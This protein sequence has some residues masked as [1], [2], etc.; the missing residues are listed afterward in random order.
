M[1]SSVTGHIEVSLDPPKDPHDV[2][3]V[4][5][6]FGVSFFVTVWALLEQPLKDF[7]VGLPSTWIKPE[8]PDVTVLLCPTGTY[9]RDQADE[10]LKHPERSRDWS[11]HVSSCFSGYFQTIEGGAGFWSGS[12]QFPTKSP[13]YQILGIPD[14]YT[15][16]IGSPGWPFEGPNATPDQD[17]GLAQLSNRILV[18][19][20]GMPL[21]AGSDAKR[22]GVAWMALPLTDYDGYYRLQHKGFPINNCL[23]WFGTNIENPLLGWDDVQGAS[24]NNTD[25]QLWRL[26]PNE[27][28]GGFC[29]VNRLK[30]LQS[31]SV[32][33]TV[34]FAGGVKPLKM[35]P[36]VQDYYYI[37][38]ETQPVVPVTSPAR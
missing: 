37:V 34:E 30:E 21:A 10:E 1:A 38:P 8:N 35:I 20:D 16:K 27:Q 2:D 22:L 15:T 4:T 31:K 26:V 36:A 5:H 23:E 28:G 9:V 14:C 3:R 17:M 25:A 13:K 18:P 33:P 7:Q 19:P 29:L 24:F 32:D 6:G 12:T 11:N